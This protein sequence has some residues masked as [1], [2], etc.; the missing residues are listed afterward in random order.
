[1]Y[2][3][4]LFSDYLCTTVISVCAISNTVDS[5][6]LNFSNVPENNLRQRKLKLEKRCFKIE[7]P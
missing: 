7:K 5:H 3:F 4:N 2:L 6:Y 1:M